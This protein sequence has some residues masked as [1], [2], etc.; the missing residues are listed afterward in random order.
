M[1]GRAV[2]SALSQDYGGPLEVIVADGSDTPAMA[3]AIRRRFPQVRVIPNPERV[4]PHGLNRALRAAAH[5]IIVRCDARS[6]LPPGYVAQ[7][8]ETLARTGAANVGGRM[9]PV[10]RRPSSGRWRWR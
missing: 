2:G 10:G 7:A 9:N 6:V 5:P 8:V 3:D 4:I 1:L